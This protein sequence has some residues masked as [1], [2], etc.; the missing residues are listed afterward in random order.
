MGGDRSERTQVESAGSLADSHVQPGRLG[1]VV[2]SVSLAPRAAKTAA[3]FAKATCLQEWTALPELNKHLST[4]LGATDAPQQ[5]GTN[6]KPHLAPQLLL[7][8]APA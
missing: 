1:V 4:F 5:A 6:S 3:E 7:N 8:A 2:P